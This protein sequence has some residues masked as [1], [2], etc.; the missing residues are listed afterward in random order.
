MAAARSSGSPHVSF[1]LHHN[2]YWTAA[3][4]QPALCK[5]SVKMGNG[6]NL[7]RLII[8]HITTANL[9]S[10]VCPSWPF[11]SN[12]R[13]MLLMSGGSVL[14]GCFFRPEDASGK[15]EKNGHVPNTTITDEVYLDVTMCPTAFK[16]D[17]IVGESYPICTDGH[18]LGRLVIGL[19]GKQVPQTVSNFKAMCTGQAGS[20]Y[21]GTIV[22]RIVPGQ[23]I[24]AGRQGSRE[25]GEVSPP[26]NLAS[27]LETIT[28]DA[29]TLRHTRPG[30]V[31]LCL[32]LNDDDDKFKLKKDYRNVEFLITT[33]PGPAPQL[34]NNNIVFGTVLKGLDVV[35]SIA[36][37]PVYNPNERI[38]QFNDLAQFL[39]DERA[40]N[41]R[42]FWYRPLKALYISDCG[43]L[44]PS[45]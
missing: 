45:P 18:L 11:V 16:P 36:A 21:Q 9:Q 25:R 43:A 4:L 38:K 28:S 23:Y 33:G 13:E 20:S 41:A 19:Y 1:L 5:M 12:R 42:N 24:Q 14:E 29:F 17:R 15:T 34:D 8:R 40:S 22:H 27:N 37:V 26:M 10:P 6:Q 2:Y 44:K 31:S 32:S 7:G 3:T 39:G 35:T 30:T